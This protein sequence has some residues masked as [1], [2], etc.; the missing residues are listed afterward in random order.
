MGRFH[1]SSIDGSCRRLEEELE[2][3]GASFDFPT[4]ELM[5]EIE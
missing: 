1:A 4:S 5:S 3:T 2:V